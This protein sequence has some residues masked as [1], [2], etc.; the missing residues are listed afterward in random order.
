MPR[1]VAVPPSSPNAGSTAQEELNAKNTRITILVRIIRI[2]LSIS[3]KFDDVV[4]LKP[5]PL[6]EPIANQS[7][8]IIFT[9]IASRAGRKT[10]SA[11]V[12]A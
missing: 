9:W 8:R 12:S 5:T 7:A 3:A 11:R 1:A 6:C 10:A 4:C 2:H